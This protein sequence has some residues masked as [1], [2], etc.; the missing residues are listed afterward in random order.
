MGLFNALITIMSTYKGNI[1][2]E[3][4]IKPETFSIINAIFNIYI[5]NSIYISGQVALK[6]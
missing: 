1:L 2:V 6:I 3:L 5:W 4:Q